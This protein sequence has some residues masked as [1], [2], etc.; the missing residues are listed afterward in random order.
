MVADL[1][2]RLP[3]GDAAFDNVVSFE[4]LEH[5]AEPRMMLS[6]AFRV[7]RAGGE[8]TLSVPFQWWL[9]EEPW[10]YYRYTRDGLRYLLEKAGF[11]N[12][13]VVSTTGFW[14]M[15]LLKLNHRTLRLLRDPTI[16]RAASRA[17]LI[18]F[19]WAGQHAG[20]LPGCW[21]DERETAGYF[22]T[23]VKP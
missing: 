15:W 12:V 4:V 1:N 19:W 23:A 17:V 18:P 11:M 16:V 22:V 9:H 8:L 5:L 10:D 6:E 14:S 3:V 21:P 13:E 7:L 2:G 20:R